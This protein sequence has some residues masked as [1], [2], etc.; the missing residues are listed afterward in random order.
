MIL[1]DPGQSGPP[2]GR[3]TSS[4]VPTSTSTVISCVISIDRAIRIFRLLP[5]AQL[6]RKFDP[7]WTAQCPVPTSS[8]CMQHEDYV[9]LPSAQCGSAHRST[10]C[11]QHGTWKL[12]LLVT[13]YPTGR[14]WWVSCQLPLASHLGSGLYMGTPKLGFGGKITGMCPRYCLS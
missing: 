3:T 1:G 2:P 5:F 10:E 13:T 11:C 14:D 12:Q 9:G 4:T 7:A 8:S 6:Q